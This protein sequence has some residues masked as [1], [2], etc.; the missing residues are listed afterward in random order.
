MVVAPKDGEENVVVRGQVP[1][2]VLPSNG[3][4]KVLD[5]EAVQ[6]KNRVGLW[7]FGS[8]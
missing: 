8:C 7:G 4:A 5:A 2:R 3:A 6:G 1:D